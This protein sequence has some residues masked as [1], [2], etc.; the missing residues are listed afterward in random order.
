M[1]HYIL[2]FSCI[3]TLVFSANLGTYK[4][5]IV[6]NPRNGIYDLVG[7][8]AECP[9]TGAMKTVQVIYT[10]SQLYYQMQCY[11]SNAASIEYDESVIKVYTQKKSTNYDLCTDNRFI[12][13]DR[14]QIACTKDF[15][16]SS[17]YLEK[18]G[19]NCRYTYTCVAVKSTYEDVQLTNKATSKLDA[20][21]GAMTGLTTLKIGDSG[22]NTNA[23]H[24][25]RLQMDYTKSTW[26][27]KYYYGVIT[28]RNMAVVKD[29]YLAKS[30]KL[31]EENTEV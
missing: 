18:S 20:K 16:L 26:E 12:W 10:S 25:F 15:A 4:S 11:S 24:N 28:L 27:A 19:T 23:L 14:Q 21:S 30:K 3:I 22:S 1:N 31:R 8:K 9:Y 29:D 13:L 2:L 17:F 7:L 6:S 5:S